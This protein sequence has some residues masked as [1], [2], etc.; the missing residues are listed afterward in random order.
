MTTSDRDPAW[1]RARAN[2]MEIARMV[3]GIRSRGRH[4]GTAR[5]LL[6]GMALNKVVLPAARR[7]FGY[8]GKKTRAGQLFR[9]SLP[10]FMDLAGS[11]AFSASASH[12]HAS[13][14]FCLHY[15]PAC[16]SDSRVHPW[17]CRPPER[18]GLTM[19]VGDRQRLRAT[20]RGSDH[21]IT[22]IAWEVSVPDMAKD[23]PRYLRLH[24]LCRVTASAKREIGSRYL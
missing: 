8:S 4:A 24:S 19:L 10:V 20:S 18:R 3:A 16:Q 13:P 1:I 11:S 7:V 17:R 14:M 23:G 15:S 2:C 6:A 21:H 12:R 9:S 22:G 5:A